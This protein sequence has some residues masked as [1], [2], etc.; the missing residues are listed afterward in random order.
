AGLWV[1]RSAIEITVMPNPRLLSAARSLSVPMA[2]MAVLLS[3][4]L[5]PMPPGMLQALSPGAYRVYEIALPGW[6][7]V[8]RPPIQLPLSSQAHATTSGRASPAAG[9]AQ[10]RTAN[11]PAAA[12]VPASAIYPI[13][14]FPLHRW[15][16]L[17]LSP[18]A[19]AASL[20]EFLALSVL[21]FL[22]LLY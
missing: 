9:A 17:S 4:Q 7:D 21:F 1:V 11:G 3:V 14:L 2:A 12:A 20:L 16:P 22:V 5:V 15:L 10:Q 8:G 13:P 19:T 18:S 6:P